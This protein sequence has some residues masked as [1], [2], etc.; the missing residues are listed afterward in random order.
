MIDSIIQHF[1]LI[2]PTLKPLKK[3]FSD[4]WKHHLQNFIWFF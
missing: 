3:T 1:E 4:D 2:K